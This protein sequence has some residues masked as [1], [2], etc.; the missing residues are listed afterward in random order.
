MLLAEASDRLEDTW[1]NPDICCLFA[2]QVRAYMKKICKP[3]AKMI[4]LV[5]TLE[6][7]VRDLIEANGLEAGIAFPTG[8]SLN[9]VAA[10]W[11]PNGGDNTVLQYDD[12]MKLG[13]PCHFPQ[14]L[15]PL[16]LTIYP[17]PW[18][19]NSLHSKQVVVRCTCIW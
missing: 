11:T 5:E 10:H 13:Q 12:V 6:Q 18:E 3:G 4:D 8:C 19:L 15:P 14:M 2:L 9:Y 7:S 17:F 16:M 1:L